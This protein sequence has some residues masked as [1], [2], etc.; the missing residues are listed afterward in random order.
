MINRIVSWT[1][2]AVTIGA[3]SLASISAEDFRL[4]GLAIVGV[5]ASLLANYRKDR[6]DARFSMVKTVRAEIELC[7]ACKRTGVIPNPCPRNPKNRPKGC[8][9]EKEN[10]K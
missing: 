5:L 1:G 6:R 2:N 4:W 10:T 7:D 9:L 8:L 3:A